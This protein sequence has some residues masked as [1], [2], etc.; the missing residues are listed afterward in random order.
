MHDGLNRRGLEY[1]DGV[2]DIRRRNRHAFH[3]EFGS[4]LLITRR[5]D[6][7]ALAYVARRLFSFRKGREEP[8]Y[9][10][11]RVVV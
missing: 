8:D 6:R 2:G 9:G 1:R 4:D 3:C 7:A 5:T 10:V 11:C